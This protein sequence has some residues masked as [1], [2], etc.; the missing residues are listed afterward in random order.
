LA[1]SEEETKRVLAAIQQRVPEV[2]SCPVCG[3]RDWTLADGLVRLTLQEK[4]GV[5]VLGGRNMPCVALTCKRC[6]NTLLLNVIVLG[7]RDLAT[8]KGEPE[9]KGE[10]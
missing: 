1:F 3:Q 9:E 5:V 6:G 8:E 2:A 10:S 4:R 7:L